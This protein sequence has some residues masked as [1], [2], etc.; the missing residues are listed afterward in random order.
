MF[1]MPNETAVIT[2][3]FKENP[4]KLAT[5]AGLTFINGKAEWNTVENADGYVLQLYKNRVRNIQPRANL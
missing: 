5:P 3:A 4:K 1:I 2:G